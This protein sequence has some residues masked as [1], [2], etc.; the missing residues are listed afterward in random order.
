[1]GAASG[2]GLERLD[3]WVAGLPGGLDAY[4]EVQA[5]GSLVRST[6]EGQPVAELLARL[7]P[8]L[9]RLAAEPPMGSEWV[10]EAHVDGLLLAIADA[11]GMTD[12]ELYA[13]TR[14]RNRALFE[15]PAYRILMAVMSPAALVRFA[16]GR[17]ANWHRGTTLE[18]EGMADDGVRG[19]LRFPRGLFDARLLRVFGEAFVAALQL[20]SAAFPVVT[21]VE[22]GPESA[23]YLVRW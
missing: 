4:P 7:P 15:S 13:W 8:Q 9:R 14:A 1:M 2:T 17:W 3:R 5:K 12:D 22:A 18:I 23:R 6:L 19:I 21:V 10:P 16:G 11:R 20:A